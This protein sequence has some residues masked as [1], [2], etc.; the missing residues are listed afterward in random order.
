M[1][2]RAR[3][4]PEAFA[5]PAEGERPHCG[6]REVTTSAGL[7]VLRDLERRMQV[8]GQRRMRATGLVGGR[9]TLRASALVPGHGGADPPPGNSGALGRSRHGDSPPPQCARAPGLTPGFDGEDRPPGCA[10]R[11]LRRK[12][13]TA[14]CPSKSHSVSGLK[15][16]WAVCAWEPRPAGRGRVCHLGHVSAEGEE[17]GQRPSLRPYAR[18]TQTEALCASPCNGALG[19][20]TGRPSAPW[21]HGRC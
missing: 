8:S 3:V 13:V 2:W 10:R 17:K 19:C 12:I 5:S 4:C 11:C 16:G 14:P 7:G 18:Q 9:A 20:R 6:P 1:V 21:S 15:G